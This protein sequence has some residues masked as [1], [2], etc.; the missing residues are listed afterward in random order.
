LKILTDVTINEFHDIL[1]FM[2]NSFGTLFRITTWGESHGPAMG[3]VIDGC[4][5]G[6]KLS[7][8]DLIPYLKKRAPGS[9]STVSPRK[10]PDHPQIL[11]GLYE[12]KTTGAPISVLIPNQDAKSSSYQVWKGKH[13][14]G[15][16]SFTY[17]EKYGIYDPRGGGR[18]SARETVCRVAAG[19]VAQK[20]LK[21]YGIEIQ[22]R[23]IVMGEEREPEKFEALLLKMVEEGDSIG[24][25]VQC[26]VQGLPVGLGEPVYLKLEAQMASAM[27]SIP[28]TKGFEIGEGFGA[29]AM[30]GSEHNDPLIEGG[31]NHAGGV[32]GG[33]TTGSALI[34]RV[35]F[36]PTAS[37]KKVQQTITYSGEKTELPISETGRHDPCTA[38]RGAAVVEAMAAL[39]L[40]DF[41]LLNRSTK[42]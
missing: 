20:L 26:E 31:S 37:I 7:E 29:V 10:E 38:V 17:L 40:A 1:A 32:L 21:E 18:A 19:A 24:G 8:N 14:P 4:P 41:I 9:S 35:P 22:T 16:A 39:V 33:I 25:L 36:K 34:F 2:R 12:G 28:A 27:L 3:V 30:R 15:H 5:A 13:R 11:S 42:I 6:L 23:L